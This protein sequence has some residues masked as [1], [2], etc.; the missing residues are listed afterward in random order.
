M[1]LYKKVGVILREEAD[2]EAHKLEL[3]GQVGRCAH[4]ARSQ[5]L[6]YT[7]YLLSIAEL[8]LIEISYGKHPT[9]LAAKIRKKM[10]A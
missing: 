10:V 1:M 7:A 2:E 3:L 4:M 5:H 6:D 8:E 9:H